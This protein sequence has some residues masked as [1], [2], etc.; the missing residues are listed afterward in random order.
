[1]VNIRKKD[2]VRVDKIIFTP[3]S[4]VSDLSDL[5]IQTIKSEEC[6]GQ[7]IKDAIVA[8]AA[9]AKGRANRNFPPFGY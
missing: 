2:V 5:I 8:L 3:M 7:D 9:I 6:D 1:M 4:R